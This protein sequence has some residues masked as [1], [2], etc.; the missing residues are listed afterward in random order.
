[1]QLINHSPFSG[2]V[3]VDVNRDGADTLVMSIKATYE[4]GGSDIPRLAHVQDDLVFNDAFAGEPGS[5]S[6]LFESDANW[7]R[8]ATDIALMGYAY[9]QRDG[10][11]ETDV[12]LRVGGLVKTAHVFGDRTWGNLLGMTQI[13]EPKPFE[14]IPLIYERAFGGTDDSPE[15]PGDMEGEPRNPVGRGLRAKKSRKPVDSI[16]LPNIE[17]PR[18]LISRLGDRPAPVGF[19]FIAKSWKPRSDYAGT[20]DAAWQAERMPL[21][22]KDFNPKF[23]TA[24]SEG[25][26]VPFLNGGEMVDLLNLTPARQERFVIPKVDMQASFLVDASPTLIKMQL[27]VIVI[28][29]VKTKLVMVWHGSHSVHGMVDDIRWVLAEGGPV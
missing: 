16:T 11:R 17:D 14:R 26:S 7:G 1:M 29:A 13:S 25:L 20:Y 23:Y 5:S 9:P 27:D 22:P 3:F 4:F 6:L 10:D 18:N 21:L 8:Q 24:A 2:G 19:T 15:Q 28:D 12:A